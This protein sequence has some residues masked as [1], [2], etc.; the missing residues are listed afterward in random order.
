MFG[1]IP[2]DDFEIYLWNERIGTYQG[3]KQFGLEY[4]GDVKIKMNVPE[5]VLGVYAVDST[6]GP[7]IRFVNG[8]EIDPASIK[9]SSR[10]YSRIQVDGVDE[11]NVD[12]LVANLNKLLATY[13][14]LTGDVFMTAS[15]GLRKDAK[16]RRRLS[17]EDVKA[18]IERGIKDG[19]ILRLSQ[20]S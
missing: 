20:L 11:S 14:E 6:S 9:V 13:R 15:K 8:S 16:Y 19:G 3:L 12:A 5:G 1:P 17:W 2:T 7:T 4:K 18:L 10:F